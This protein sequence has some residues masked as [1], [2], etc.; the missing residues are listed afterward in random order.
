MSG[1]RRL[2]EACLEALVSPRDL[3]RLAASAPQALITT[4]GITPVQLAQLRLEDALYA[5]LDHPPRT[6]I[7][8]NWM[9]ARMASQSYPPDGQL[10]NAGLGSA[11]EMPPLPW[12]S[13]VRDR[14]LRARF[15]LG[16]LD[17]NGQRLGGLRSLL[18][19]KDTSWVAKAVAASF[20]SFGERSAR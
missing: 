13:S 7:D 3:S 19:E 15:R 2:S 8:L 9:M 10:D 4:G 5:N 11:V 17:D 14:A 18:C 20:A 6:P 1:S 16:G 12:R